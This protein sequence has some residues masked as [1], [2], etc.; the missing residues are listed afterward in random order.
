MIFVLLSRFPTEKAYGV[1]TQFSARALK[2]LGYKTVIIT[3]KS[4]SGENLKNEVKILGSN[5]RLRLLDKR[6]KIPLSIRYIVFQIILSILIRVEFRRENLV[7]WTRDSLIAILLSIFSKSVVVLEI[8]RVPNYFYSFTI[9]I[10][11]FKKNIVIAP[12]SFFLKE[13]LSL[14]DKRVIIAPMS[15][16]KN[17]LIYFN[18]NK[19]RKTNKIIYVG[20][21][22]SSGI[23]L[24]LDLLNNSAKIISKSNPTWTIEIVGISKA[25]F[26]T[27]ISEEISWNIKV[28]GY[29]KRADVLR[30]LSSAS[31]ALVVYPNDKYFQDSFPIKII[32]YAS[33]SAAIVASKTISH[34]NILGHDKCMYFKPDSSISLANSIN[35][36]IRNPKKRREISSLA[37]DWAKDFTYETRVLN[38]MNEVNNIKKGM[39][40]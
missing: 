16:N 22:H 21:I 10:A 33:A 32:E 18:K 36:L 23:P 24:H 19:N 39:Y 25:D 30:S 9:Y 5:L 1:T 13:K 15:V 38:I 7:F 34:I 8:H 29:K 14:H 12:I 4:N 27:S 11:K 3:P 17:D 20:S 28:I 37:R 35:T 40:S 31:I 2:H 6:L 26:L